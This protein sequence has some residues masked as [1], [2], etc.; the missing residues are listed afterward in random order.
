[1]SPAPCVSVVTPFLDAE[2][3]L[4]E[5]IASVRAQTVA[6][7]ELI[8]VDDGSSDS[9]RAIAL[10]AAAADE[11]IRLVDPPPGSRGA[12]AARNAGMRVARGDFL[13]FLDAD[14]LFE[15]HML[16]ATLSAAQA[17]P[18]A[19]L[20]YG[21]TRWWYPDGRQS[22]WTETTDGRA[23]RLHSPPALLRSII[24]LQDG[25]VPCTCSVLIRRAAVDAVG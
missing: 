6:D 25:H 21:P 13:A 3:F 17:N 14:D 22:D 7:W 2:A 1:M 16:A 15:R 8:L 20:I 19:A 10:E 12:A 4:P 5:A 23:G 18:E 11:R 9:S 24:L